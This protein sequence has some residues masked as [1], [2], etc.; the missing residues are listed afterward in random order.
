[1]IEKAIAAFGGREVLNRLSSAKVTLAV[2][3][4]LNA[5]YTF[6][7]QSTVF[8]QF[9]DKLK[10]TQTVTVHK[11]DFN[12]SVGFL[13]VLLGTLSV[14]TGGD[15]VMSATLGIN[16]RAAWEVRDNTARQ[17]AKVTEAEVRDILY[18]NQCTQLLM[19][20]GDDVQLEKV[21]ANGVT[22][23]ITVHKAG[24]PDITL[25]FDQRSG[26]LVRSSFVEK[27]KD[28]KNVTFTN[29]YG[30]YQNFDGLNFAKTVKI[31]KSNGTVET[32]I[33][34]SIVPMAPANAPATFRV[35][36]GISQ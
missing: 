2:S 19:L 25:N 13:G 16:G 23:S 30:N 33:I 34:E 9:P 29:E 27:D 32:D 4:N 31:T 5:D 21:F 10:V 8:Q 18:L 36:A 28:G 26:F 15:T 20:L 3:G 35:P 14:N 12:K 22:T 24:K 11:D 1:M 17:M 7:G 6:S